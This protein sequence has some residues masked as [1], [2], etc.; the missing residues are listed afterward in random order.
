MVP[1]ALA[2][3]AHTFDRT[4]SVREIAGGGL[5]AVIGS[6]H[7]RLGSPSFVD[8]PGIASD[9]VATRDGREIALLP[10]R[11]RARSDAHDALSTLVRAGYETHLVSGDLA[12]RTEAFGHRLGFAASRVRAHASPE[13][14]AAYVAALSGPAMMVGDGINDAA[15][16]AASAASVTPA[17]D[18]PFLASR[19]DCYVRGPLG[20]GLLL[21]LTEAA[22]LRSV[23]REAVTFGVVYNLFAV[24]AAIS[25]HV[26]PLAAALVM[27]ASSLAIVLWV[28]FRLR[29][30]ASLHFSSISR[31]FA[32][33][34]PAVA[35]AS[36]GVA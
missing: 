8:C 27:P 25:G 20:P 14:K 18:R 1:D 32:T 30:G 11:E 13:E 34:G 35:L 33:P 29:D 28:A 15:A 2:T 24:S 22:R 6:A 5:E 26:T 17:G 7:Y 19:A 10:T 3:E 23:A 31:T 16:M 21:L 4:L 12:A 9:L 36:R